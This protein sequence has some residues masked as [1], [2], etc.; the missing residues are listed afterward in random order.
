MYIFGTPFGATFQLTVVGKVKTTLKKLILSFVLDV[1][2]RI[3]RL[4]S[5]KLL[6]QVQQLYLTNVTASALLQHGFS[7]ASITASTQQLTAIQD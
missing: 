1:F 2:S 5:Y 7:I 6:Q 4:V 3:V